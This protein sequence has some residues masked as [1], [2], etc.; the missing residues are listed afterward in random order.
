MTGLIVNGIQR[1]ANRRS[2]LHWLNGSDAHG[3]LRSSRCQAV[4]PLIKF[5]RQ[6]T[7]DGIFDQ[8]PVD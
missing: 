7:V 6:E 5:V 1:F 2:T 3:G 8:L 4:A